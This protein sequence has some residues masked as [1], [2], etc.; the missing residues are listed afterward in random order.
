MRDQ[1][2]LRILVYAISVSAF[3]QVNVSE[4]VKKCDL[5]KETIIWTM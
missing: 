1:S 5:K 4:W 2:M 3:G